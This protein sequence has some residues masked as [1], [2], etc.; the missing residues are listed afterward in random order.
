[1]RAKRRRPPLV[2]GWRE[3]TAIGMGKDSSKNRGRR[4]ESGPN[5]STCLPTT[6]RPWGSSW[7]RKPPR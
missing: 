7:T 6:G 4:R 5:V 3:K 1:V 2:Q